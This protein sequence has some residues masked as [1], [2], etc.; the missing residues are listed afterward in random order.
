MRRIWLSSLAVAALTATA[1]CGPDESA[2]PDATFEQPGAVPAADPSM[3][4]A[5]LG[6]GGTTDTG[7]VAP[8]PLDTT[9]ISGGAAGNPPTTG[10]TPP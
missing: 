6:T 10:T 8:M 1:A 5:T 9:G 7:G 4:G 3:P 2:E